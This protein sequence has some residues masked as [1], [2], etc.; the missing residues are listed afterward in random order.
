MVASLYVNQ[1]EQLPAALAT[2]AELNLRYHHP[3]FNV[4]T[5]K[6]VI[7][8]V[9]LRPKQRS[10]W[11]PTSLPA[12]HEATP[13]LPNPAMFDAVAAAHEANVDLHLH[14][15]GDGRSTV[16]AGMRSSVPKHFTPRAI[17]ARRFVTSKLSMRMT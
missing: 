2:L 17:R 6:L 14:A 5:L 8:T 11:S 10:C 3:L 7:G 15:I 13:L 16:G 4:S 1:P 9:P 12:G